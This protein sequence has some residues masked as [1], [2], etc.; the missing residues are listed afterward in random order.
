[1]CLKH[2]TFGI[3]KF[4]QSISYMKILFYLSLTLISFSLFAKKDAPNFVIFLTDDMGW[5]DLGCY[6]HAEIKTP[7]LDKFAS[8]G[9][10]FTEAYSACAVCSPSRAA[11]LTGRTPFRNGVWRWVPP[12]SPIHL[13][14]SEIT[15]PELLKKKG[16]ATCHVG[17][18]HLNGYFNHAK[19]P[20]PDDH[21]FDH[22]MATQNN[23]HPN[24]KNPTNFVLNGKDMGRLN[25]YSAPL[26]VE[27]G[28]RW[29]KDIKE[30]GKP[31]FLNVWTHE[32]HLPIESSPE[33]MK[34]YLHLKDEG[35]RQH[36]GNI[37]QIDYAFGKL[38]DALDKMDLAG[39]TFVF[40]TSDNGPEG[41][42]NKGRTRGSTGGL[43]ERKRSSHEGG[44]R[45]PGIARW[46]G[47]IPVGEHKAP[48]IGSDLFS[49]ILGI[50]DIPLPTDRTIDGADFMPLFSGGKI[51]RKVPMYWRNHL[52]DPQVHVALRKGD[53]KVLANVQLDKFQLYK[54]DED[55]QERNDLAQSKPQKLEEMS[56][57]LLSVH[58]QIEE[59][60][61]SEWWK[62]QLMS[63]KSK[64]K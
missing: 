4:T 35:L 18:W 31:F 19:H 47:R 21:G 48:I 42:G 16:Y 40:F 34:P 38:M 59:E 28:I 57:L 7:N 49:T 63:K 51:D 25:G 64:K 37:T 44:I 20:Q 26:V 13:R 2:P 46:P 55:W 61:P 29:L 23:A 8:Q 12:K 27:E 32:P 39:D 54:I 10:K 30:P 45:V 52:A 24:H 15:L 58:K 43:R 14:E 60:G 5:G 36:H 62:N 41:S 17:K 33:F 56:A 3:L 11:I 53:W 50:V 22:W 6:G 1:M 9:T